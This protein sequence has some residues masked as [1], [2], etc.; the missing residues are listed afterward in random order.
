MSGAVVVTGSQQSAQPR[1]PSM[2]HAVSASLESMPGARVAS[3]PLVVS[4]L[5]LAVR[6]APSSVLAVGSRFLSSVVSCEL[7]SCLGH[8]HQNDSK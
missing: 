6:G 3:L 1:S 2:Q 8:L 4:L 7:R 5:L